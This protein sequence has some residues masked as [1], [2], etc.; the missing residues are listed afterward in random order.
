VEKWIRLGKTSLALLAL[1]SALAITNAAPGPRT[2]LTPPRIDIARAPAPLFDDPEWHGATDPF[3]IWNPFRHLWFMYYTQ[4]RA[5]MPNPNG[6]NWVHGSK[7]GIA[8]S[9]N[10]LSWTYLGTAKGD[11]DLS[12]PLAA[13]GLG[14]EPGVTWWA[15]C[16]VYQGKTLHMF[17][18]MVDGVYT[19]WTGQRHILHFT[20]TDG[21]TW[22]YINTCKLNSDRVIDPMVYRIKDT[23][24]M[25][26]KDEAAGSHTYRSESKDLVEWTNHQQTDSDGRQEA[27][28][29]FHWLGAYWMIVDSVPDKGLRIYKSSNGVDQWEYNNTV[30]AAA[31]GTRPRDNNVGHHPGIVLQTARDGSEQCL[32]F[33]FTHQGRHTVMQL[34]ELELGV[35]GKAFCN[36]NKYSSTTF[37]PLY[38]WERGWGEGLPSDRPQMISLSLNATSLSRNT[39]NKMGVLFRKP[40]SPALLPKGEG[41]NNSGCL[42]APTIFTGSHQHENTFHSPPLHQDINTGRRCWSGCKTLA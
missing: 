8:T 38:H 25:V 36:R 9:Q 29:V 34:A 20:S 22:K 17:V 2:Q 32:L 7:I 31:D 40:S 41:R 10:G 39:T 13:K 3:V 35:D 11:H 24:F 21:V 37:I 5:T 16:F 14:P 12:E 33:Y 26:Y 1:S 19:N 28:F 23:W 42:Q 4:R 15:P 6:V 27:P 30:L 18:T